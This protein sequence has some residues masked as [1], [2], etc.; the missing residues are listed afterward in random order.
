MVA[1]RHGEISDPSHHWCLLSTC[2]PSHSRAYMALGN[3]VA[4][5]QSPTRIERTGKD[6]QEAPAASASTEWDKC[7]RISGGRGQN[8]PRVSQS[9]KISTPWG[10]L[11][12]SDAPLTVKAQ[13]KS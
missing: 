11:W 8:S 12:G 5:P 6:A 13:P 9:L 7:V 3:E 2:G 10:L 1:F 4:G